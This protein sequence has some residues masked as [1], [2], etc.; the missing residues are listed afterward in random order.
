MKPNQ[1][2][3]LIRQVVRE[4]NDYQ[5][6]FKTMLDKTGKS[7]GS[8]SD[9]EKKAFFNA[10][11]KAA[12]AKAAADLKKFGGNAAAANSFANWGKN[13]YAG[14]II[15][16]FAKGGPIIGTDVIPSM[17]TPGEFVMSRYAVESFGLDNM[18]AI[19][20]GE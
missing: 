18:K 4:E 9:N 1:L 3:E 8:M 13:K 16:R 5:E 7:I 11:D 19:N 10:V 17:L 12:K 2:K 15:K 6:L 20:N 14:G